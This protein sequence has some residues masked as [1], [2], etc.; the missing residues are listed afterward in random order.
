MMNRLKHPVGPALLLAVTLA[1]C[2]L[3]PLPADAV[4]ICF[5]VATEVDVSTRTKADLVGDSGIQSGTIKL[6]G[7]KGTEAVFAGT[8]L[9]YSGSAWTYSPLKYWERENAYAFRAVFPFDASVSSGSSDEV[10][11]A[12]DMA[13]GYDLMV[14]SSEV[15]SAPPTDN[16]VPLVFQHTTAAVRFLFKDGDQDTYI[17]SFELQG[18]I[19]SGTMTYNNTG[20]L[21]TWGST[22]SATYVWPGTS[23]WEVPEDYDETGLEGWYFAI[24]QDDLTGATLS[25]TYTV[26]N[27]DGA[28]VLPVTIPLNTGSVTSWTRANA[29]TYKIQI[30]AN[31]IEFDVGWEPWDSDGII[32]YDLTGHQEQE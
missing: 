1:G 15:A 6:Y 9:S 24:P 23:P 7:S 22:S 4:A 28:Q 32:D 29:Y 17:T 30:Q 21:P 16:S 18:L 3:E 5:S 27:A 11:V 31:A 20:D 14:A 13:S 19:T 25:F 8:E 10:V 2:R 26:G 12:Y